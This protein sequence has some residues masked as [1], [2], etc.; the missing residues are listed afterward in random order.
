MGER[1]KVP[2]LVNMLTDANNPPYYNFSYVNEYENQ[3]IIEKVL[4]YLIVI[5][6]I[7]SRSI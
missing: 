6:K 5:K 2:L 3:I 7:K 4:M 1:I